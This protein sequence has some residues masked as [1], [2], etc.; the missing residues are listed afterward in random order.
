M[1][2]KVS[3]D[4]R[5]MLYTYIML[6]NQCDHDNI[7]R[8]PLANPYINDHL[9]NIHRLFSQNVNSRL[10]TLL[11]NSPVSYWRTRS[12]LLPPC[13]YTILAF[14]PEI[15]ICGSGIRQWRA[16]KQSIWGNIFFFFFLIFFLLFS[17]LFF[18][19]LTELGLGRN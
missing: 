17:R 1:Y 7:I 9:K 5:F 6:W 16:T 12:F 15:A 14:L 2:C 19:F 11:H 3:H 18:F 4:Y 10:N 13:W 8:W